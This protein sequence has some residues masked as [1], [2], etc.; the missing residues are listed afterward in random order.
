[1][2]EVQFDGPPFPLF[3][4]VGERQFGPLAGNGRLE[5]QGGSKRIRAVGDAVFLDRDFG[6][7]AL[8]A[9]GRHPLAIPD[10]GSAVVTVKGGLY[11]G[12]QMSVDGRPLPGP[13]P[14]QVARIAAGPHTIRFSWA[15][16]QLAGLD[17]QQSFTISAGGHFLISAVPGNEQVTI[18]QLR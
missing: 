13:Y 10:T 11:G 18:Q 15:S 5:V 8:K 6:V 4:R 12:L 3:V 9:G 7:V 17:L 14:A 2:I 1:V 16:G